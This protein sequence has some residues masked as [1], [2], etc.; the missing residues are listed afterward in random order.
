MLRHVYD[1]WNMD[2]QLVYRVWKLESLI[3]SYPAKTSVCLSW[4]L[5]GRPF[6]RKTNHACSRYFEQDQALA[7]D[8]FF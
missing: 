7:I 4:I 8:F 1:N 3:F 2:I 6:D 5:F